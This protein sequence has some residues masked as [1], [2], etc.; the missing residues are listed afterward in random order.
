[1]Q[2]ISINFINISSFT[3]S[4]IIAFC[5]DF[6]S[7]NFFTIPY[8][9]C[10]F[11]PKYYLFSFN[12]YYFRNLTNNKQITNVSKVQ[13][14]YADRQLNLPD[15]R[16]IHQAIKD[17]F[18]AEGKPML[19]MDY[20]FCS[21]EHL[22]QINQTYLQHDFYTDIVTFDLSENKK[23]IIGEIYIS[24]DRIKDNAKTLKQPFNT[25]AL[26]VIFHGAL[27]LCGYGDKKEKE[28]SIMRSKEDYYIKKYQGK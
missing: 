9:S 27:H 18:K 1:M 26:R 24:I 22:L 28:I 25:E 13:F 8:Y 21:D 6:N 19:Q 3:N 16:N 4:L 14:H 7:D 11:T 5:P 15:K 10:E 23:E 20:I 17:L 12:K 2:P